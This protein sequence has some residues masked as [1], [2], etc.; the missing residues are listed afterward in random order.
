[1]TYKLQQFTEGKT[2]KFDAGDYGMT[3]SDED[4]DMILAY[5]K[6]L[7]EEVPVCLFK[8][9]TDERGGWKVHARELPEY[10]EVGVLCK[11][12]DIRHWEEE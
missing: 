10:I 12:D 2:V 4:V 6:K 9:R 5:G 3:I 7:K 1:M 11:Y 8:S